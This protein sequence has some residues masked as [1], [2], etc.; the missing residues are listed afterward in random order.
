MH[1]AVPAK[2]RSPLWRKVAVSTVALETDVCLENYK[3]ILSGW[4]ELYEMDDSD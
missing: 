3:H 4:V 2:L 1:F